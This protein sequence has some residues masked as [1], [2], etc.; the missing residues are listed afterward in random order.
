VGIGGRGMGRGVLMG[1]G[2]ERRGVPQTTVR[3]IV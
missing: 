2:R 3:P 1:V